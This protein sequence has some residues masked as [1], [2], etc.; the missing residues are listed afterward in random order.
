MQMAASVRSLYRDLSRGRSLCS[1]PICPPPPSEST[2]RTDVVIFAHMRLSAQAIVLA[3][4][5][6]KFLAIVRCDARVVL[7][8]E[9]QQ[10]I[11]IQGRQ[12]PFLLP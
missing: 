2:G 12:P 3:F 1:A 11:G 10:V 4:V 9:F 6:T 5:D 7:R 8:V